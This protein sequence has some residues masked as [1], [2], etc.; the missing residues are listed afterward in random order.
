MPP[1]CQGPNQNRVPRPNGR[2]RQRLRWAWARKWTRVLTMDKKNNGKI[3]FIDLAKK[4][5]TFP[6]VDQAARQRAHVAYT[7]EKETVSIWSFVGRAGSFQE[8]Q[9]AGTE[10]QTNGRTSRCWTWQEKFGKKRM[11]Q[12]K[13]PGYKARR[14]RTI[15]S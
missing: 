10:Y 8:V 13:E 11:C 14:K 12:R 2:V 5:K 6:M 1:A 7:A 15:F 9:D 4:K 3:V